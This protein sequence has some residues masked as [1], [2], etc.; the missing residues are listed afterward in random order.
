[1]MTMRWSVLGDR[2]THPGETRQTEAGGVA[3][4][5]GEAGESLP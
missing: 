1:M 5:G 3:E 4:I 2:R